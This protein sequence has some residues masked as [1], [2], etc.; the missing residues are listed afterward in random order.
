MFVM[1]VLGQALRACVIQHAVPGHGVTVSDP[2]H[3][4]HIP[5]LVVVIPG[6]EEAV[7]LAERLQK[8]IKDCPI[9]IEGSHHTITLSAGVTDIS[10]ELVDTE[11][12]LVSRADKVLYISK[13]LGGDIV[14]V[15][16]AEQG[17]SSTHN[18]HSTFHSKS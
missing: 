3:G 7:I 10:K 18:L 12:T 17:K 6:L 8:M 9:A 15:L 11:R 16:H 1:M 14:E 5:V 13:E 4:H 2:A